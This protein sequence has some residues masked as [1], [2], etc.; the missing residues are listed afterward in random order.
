MSPYKNEA[1]AA[2]TQLMDVVN[3]TAHFILAG[4]Q[5]EIADG[6]RNK[7]PSLRELTDVTMEFLNFGY[8]DEDGEVNLDSPHPIIIDFEYKIVEALVI[9]FFLYSAIGEI[10]EYY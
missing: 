3:S 5:N 7:L 8:A 6:H 2:I 1:S 9:V 4:Y 10:N